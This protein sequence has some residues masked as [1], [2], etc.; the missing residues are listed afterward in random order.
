MHNL[1]LDL[2]ALGKYEII[3]SLAKNVLQKCWYNC[4]LYVQH[5]FRIYL[6]KMLLLKLIYID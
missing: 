4:H 5:M 2:P 3:F 6:F 1:L